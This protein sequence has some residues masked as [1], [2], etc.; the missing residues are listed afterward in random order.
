MNRIA[1][2]AALALAAAV[3]HAQPLTTAFTFQGKLES[4][5]A[6]A[7]GTYDLRFTLFDAAAGGAQLGSPLCVDNVSV[8]NGLVTVQLDFGPLFAGSQ[9]FLEVQTRQDTGLNCGNATGFTTLSPRQNLTASPNAAF[10]LTA[11]A[12]TTA[13]NAT[14]LNSQ[15]A[16]FYQNAANLNAG[17]IADAR[18][19]S[20]AALLA[21]VQTFS[22]AKSF[23]A[24]AAFTVANGT[25]PFSV[26][27]TTRVTNLNADLLDGLDST[28]F[29]RLAAA[30]AFTSTNAF[31]S[32]STTGPILTVTNPAAGA[33]LTAL[34]VDLPSGN[35][36]SYALD[37]VATGFATT[38]IKGEATGYAST[39]VLAKAN[40]SSGGGAFS[41]GLH[42]VA[43]GVDPGAAVYAQNSSTYNG[44]IGIWASVA[45]P[46]AVAGYFFKGYAGAGFSHQNVIAEFED[47]DQ[48]Y[49]LL[50]TPADRERGFVFSNG[51]TQHHGGLYYTDA[52]G[53]SL[54]TGGNNT[55]IQIDSS[56]NV[57]VGTATPGAPLDV[58]VGGGQTL[59]IRRDSGLVPGINVNTTGGN[60]GVMR[61]RNSIEVWPSDDATRAGRL[62]LRNT[63]GAATIICNGGTGAFSA[64]SKSF[65]IDHPLDPQNKELW[66]SCVESDQMKNIYDGLVTTDSSGYAT[67]TLPDWFE[68]LNGDFRYQLTIIDDSD[69]L[70]DI[71][72]ARVVRRIEHN[73]FTIRTSI[74]SVAVSWQVTGVRRDPYAQK[75][76]TPVEVEKSSEDKGRYL[77]PD[78][79][80]PA[81]R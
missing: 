43:T 75:H 22:G 34:R 56:G 17:T 39:G 28:G 46:S 61:I 23:S 29:A 35:S 81:E 79:Y 1:S 66:H 12:A 59:Q 45:N 15:P 38:G 50:N 7:S 74:G 73:Q 54:R 42:A 14:Q 72:S 70:P 26:T 33:D 64:A 80:G 67:I 53:L 20:N 30:N 78:A 2:L 27:S 41:Y 69:S 4:G 57:G 16:S 11:A 13:A 9:R 21:G 31:T 48:A 37:V 8:A 18:L 36:N 51:L 5:G 55:R 47:D 68:A 3:A 71:V 76:R 77:H 10:S 63:S 25:S 52:T 58:A 65:R 62:D 44:G 60:A 32:A 6:P 40:G 24:P 19:S 49:V